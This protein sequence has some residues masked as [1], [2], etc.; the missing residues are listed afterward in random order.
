MN[1]T[2]SMEQDVVIDTLARH[3]F[4]VDKIEPFEG[5]PHPTA[6]MSKRVSR[7]Q[8]RYATVGPDC[9]VNG[10]TLKAFLLEK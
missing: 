2:L 3:G 5:E 8:T 4:G 10:I 6:F 9:T 7:H 1:D